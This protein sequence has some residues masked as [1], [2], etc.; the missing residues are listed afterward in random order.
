MKNPTKGL[1]DDSKREFLAAGPGVWGGGSPT[2][3]N[4]W[5]NRGTTNREGGITDK[6]R[7]QEENGL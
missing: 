6:G 1:E 7:E 5:K 4:L 2:Q 3:K